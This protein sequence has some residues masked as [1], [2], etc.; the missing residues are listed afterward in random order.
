MNNF[1]KEKKWNVLNTAVVIFSLLAIYSLFKLPSHDRQMSYLAN[2]SGFFK[3]FFP[4]DWSIWPELWKSLLETFQMAL[5]ATFFAIL[6]SLPLGFFSARNLSPRFLSLLTR[7]ILNAIR[8]IP[9]LI[10]ALLAVAIMGVGP[11][12]G[13]VALAFYSLGYLAKFFSDAFESLDMKVFEAFRASGASR[14]SSFIYGVWPAMRPLISAHS[15][16]MLEYNIRSASIVGYVGAGG[17]GFQLYVYQEFYEWQRFSSVLISIF[18]VVV[19]LDLF[20]EYLRSRLLNKT[21]L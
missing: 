14:V 19:I 21:S 17:I 13:V 15:I 6:I 4:P 3:N 2:F 18:I 10:W 9:S 1:L 7:M 11:R 20:G 8:S 16:W 5:G 12:A